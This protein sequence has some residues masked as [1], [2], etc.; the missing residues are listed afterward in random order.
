MSFTDVRRETA[1]ETRDAQVVVRAENLVPMPENVDALQLA[2]LAVNPATAHSL[3][4]DYVTLQP[5]DWIGLT[6]ANSGVGQCVIAL[7]KRAGIKTLA[8]VRREETAQQVREL[9][10]DVVL[11]D[12]ENL[13]DRV[14]EALGDRK[15]RILLDGGAPDLSE[16]ARSIEDGGS[17][18]TRAE[19]ATHDGIP[20]VARASWRR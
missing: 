1:S 20:A 7:A 16:L 19:L 9:G 11:L 12:G 13:G 17:V 4:N 18:V 3:L 14:A 5:A 6:L 15:L 2:M 10:A 8:I